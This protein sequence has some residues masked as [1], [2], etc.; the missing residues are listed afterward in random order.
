MSFMQKLRGRNLNVT[1]A[2]ARIF[3]LKPQNT[4]LSGAFSSI[5][6]SFDAIRVQ[7]AA[8]PDADAPDE[9]VS[10]FL[11]RLLPDFYFVNTPLSRMRRHLQLLRDLPA[12]PLQIELLCPPG[13]QFTELTLCGYEP[14]RP[15]L[16]ARI[17]GVLA[18]QGINVH[19]AW[20]HTLSDPQFPATP[21]V[22]DTFIISENSFRRT[23]PLANKNCAALKKALRAVIKE[24]NPPAKPPVSTLQVDEISVTTAGLYTLI[25]LSA[26][27]ESR[28]LFTVS[29]A[30][31]QLNLNIAH[32]QINTFENAV[33]D[34]FFVTDA[35]G[36]P[37]CAAQDSHV[38]AQLRALLER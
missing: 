18:A 33:A 8:M 1:P 24:Q 21:I 13:A 19:T 23:R 4:L 16:L 30:L 38:A 22:L 26:P 36:Q 9:Q 29:Q 15:G 17:A 28:V 10:A 20:I 14:S 2:N 5:M 25:K 32:A 3:K 35:T 34:T 37:L 11:R 12:K 7:Q 27:N 6:T 31:A